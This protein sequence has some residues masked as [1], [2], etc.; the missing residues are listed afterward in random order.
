[1]SVT[2]RDP[3]TPAERRAGMSLAAI[4]AL[5]MLGLFLI[6]PV[7]AVHAE[8]IPGGD[9][10]TL[11]GLAIGAYGLTQ[12]CLQIAYGAASD[13]FGRKPVIVFGL[14]LFVVGSVVAALADGIHW[15][16]AGRVL[17]G[18]GAISAAVTA[19]AAD[20][21]R[22]Q[23]RTKVMAMIG[24]SIGLVFALSMVAAPL[25]YAAIGMAGIFWLT[26]ALACAAIGV[27]LWVVPEAPPV[28]RANGGRFIDVLRDGQLMR[29]NFGVFALHLIQTTMWVMVPA[30][31]VAG[32]LP[33]P[34]HWKVYLP[35]V[36]LSFVV[37]VPAVIVAERRNLMK[38]V[39]NAAVCLL[40]VVQ[41][42]LWLFGEGLIPLALLLTMFF[43]AFNVLEATQP[44]WISRIAPAYAKGTALGVY[45][46]LQSL[47]LFLGGLLGGWLGQ[48]FGP[49][50]VS[51]V[52]GALALAWLL[53]SS[54]VN[55]P[56]VRAVPAPEKA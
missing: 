11:V 15:V 39:F 25:L 46:T 34:E 1:M 10:L 45:N 23:H 29:L 26:A 7:F 24:S 35:A 44:S 42:G 53:V 9:N 30:G 12:A 22:D 4:F 47:G 28:P 56:P 41:F 49:G 52:C 19:L 8:G 3:M 31:L 18:A 21:T 2:S 37:M 16:I 54:G 17:Q 14:V 40:A 20:L 43:V 38:P 27:V 50:A 6:L 5:R 51:L 48:R 13:R 33:M 36:L 55:P 32:G